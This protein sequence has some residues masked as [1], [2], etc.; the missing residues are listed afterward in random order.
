MKIKLFAIVISLLLI[1]AIPALSQDAGEPDTVRLEIIIDTVGLDGAIELWVYSDEDLKSVATGFGWDNPNLQMDTAIIEAELS[2]AF[3]IGPF[4]WQTDNN[5]DTT[6]FY[7]H[8]QFGGSRLFSDGLTGSGSAR[9]WATY[10]FKLSSWNDNNDG[11]TLDTVT[12]DPGSIAVFS[13]VT[14]SAFIPTWVGQVNVCCQIYPDEDPG[15]K[16]TV[17]LELSFNVDST[18]ATVELYGYNDEALRAVSIGFEWDNASVM[19]QSAIPV[20]LHPEAQLRNG[21]F[22]FEDNDIDVTNTNQR[23][24]FFEST[25]NATKLATIPSVSARKLWATYTFDIATLSAQVDSISIDTL[26]FNN[27]SHIRFRKWGQLFGFKPYWEGKF[28][29]WPSVDVKRVDNSPL[30]KKFTLGQNYP[31]PFNPTTQIE[32]DVPKLSQVTITV[33]NILGQEVLT[34]VDE[35]MSAG[36]YV[37][38]WNGKTNGGTD[39]SSGVYFYKMKGD[40]FTET[41]KMLLVR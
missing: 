6:N 36:S 30:P 25:N 18:I 40:N 41:K 7:Q 11:L 34:L 28:L 12:F 27:F 14:G 16:D 1:T 32:F 39:V 23:F 26:L 15:N 17:S 21:P 10:N 20:T 37:A 31:N 8:F 13:P 5:I 3:D 38:E 35:E 4:V 9:L 19:M 29:I 24:M 2:A 22:V 33:Y